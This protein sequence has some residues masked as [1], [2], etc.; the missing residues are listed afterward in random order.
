MFLSD[1]S[2][3]DASIGVSTAPVCSGSASA[4]LE[5]NVHMWESERGWRTENGNGKPKLLADG[6]CRRLSPVVEQQWD[7]HGPRALPEDSSRPAPPR[8]ARQPRLRT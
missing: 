6:C 2:G 1:S 5:R 8:R 7:R 3:R 4:V